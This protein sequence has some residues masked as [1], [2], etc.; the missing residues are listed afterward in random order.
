MKLTSLSRAILA[1]RREARAMEKAGYE[2]IEGPWQLLHGN[3]WEE[4]IVQVA[5][6]ADGKHIW[7]KTE[8]ALAPWMMT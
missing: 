5:P 3:R 1:S 8:K 7:I 4:R 2:R 6:S